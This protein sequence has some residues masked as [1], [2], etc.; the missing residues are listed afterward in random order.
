MLS[1]L[2]VDGKWQKPFRWPADLNHLWE[3]ILEIEV[4]G[5]GPDILIWSRANSGKIS[6]NFAWHEVRAESEA[7][8]W[9]KELW[10]PIQPPRMSFLCWQAALN[11]LPTLHRLKK[12]S[13]IQSD[14]CPLCGVE[15]ETTDHLF[16]HCSYSDFVWASISVKSSKTLEVTWIPPLESWLKVNS[17]GYKS[18]DRFAFGA[19]VRDHS[20][21]CL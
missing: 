6:Y 4:G 13:Q 3:E 19:L 18:E 1:T 12:W 2:I 9:T 21:D 20:G 16:L 14:L 5:E 11:K 8:S 15:D 17:D 7:M 10:H